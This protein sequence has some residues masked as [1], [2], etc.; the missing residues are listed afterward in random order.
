VHWS[1][2]AAKYDYTVDELQK[3]GTLFG[4]WVHAGS[5]PLPQ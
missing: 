3:V 4:S 5:L 2:E 1:N